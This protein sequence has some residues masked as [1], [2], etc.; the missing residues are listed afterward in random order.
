M[1][2]IILS[3][4]WEVLPHPAHSPGTAP[5]ESHLF[6]SLQHPHPGQHFRKVKDKR[7]LFPLNLCEDIH[8]LPDKYQKVTESDADQFE[9]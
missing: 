4:G 6:R 1:I 2:D 8:S 7:N 3:L 5:S 9:D